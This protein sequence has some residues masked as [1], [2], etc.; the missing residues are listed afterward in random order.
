MCQSIKQPPGG[1]EGAETQ[2]ARCQHLEVLGRRW[3]FEFLQAF[4]RKWDGDMEN[5]ILDCL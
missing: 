3:G 5:T 1:R 2:V 4:P